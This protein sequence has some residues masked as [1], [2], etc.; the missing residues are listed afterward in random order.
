MPNTKEE[1]YLAA[2]LGEYSGELPMPNTKVECYLYKLA[3]EGVPGGSGGGTVDL[4]EYAKKEDLVG[5]KTADGGEIF[6]NYENNVAIGNYSHAE[7]Y[8]TKAIKNSSHAEGS[9]TKSSGDYSHAEGVGTTALGESSHAEGN[10]SSALPKTIN[11]STSNNDIISI[12][13]S[14]Q[15]KFSLAKGKSSHVEGSDNLALANYSHSEGLYT[16]ASAYYSHAEGLRTKATSSCAH[17]EGGLT[18]AEGLYSHS[19]GHGTIAYSKN[20]HV[21]GSYNIEDTNGKYAFIIG[22]GEDDSNRSNAFAIDWNGL[23]YLNNSDTG[24]DLSNLPAKEE[25][26]QAVEYAHTH[27]NKATLN[28]ITAAK[29]ESWET[30]VQQIGDIQTALENIVEVSK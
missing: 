7:G 25:V 22:N 18:K 19:E 11:T 16:I 13:D 3:S 9:G 17:A 30:A 12:W 23:I 29:F 4:S 21:Q 26:A 2:I 8:Q 14:A 24:I 1:L 28:K 10:S 27:Q 5:Q 20:Q 15:T 6:N